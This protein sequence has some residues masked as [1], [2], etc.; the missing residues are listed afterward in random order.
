MITQ[1][2]QIELKIAE[3]HQAMLSNHPELPTFLKRIHLELLKHPELV[4]IMSNEQRSKLIAA[5]Q[6]QTG[7]SVFVASSAKVK[8]SK[9]APQMTAAEFGI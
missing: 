8:N 4:H 9:N 3:L 7:I 1:E 6:K 5:L 2:E